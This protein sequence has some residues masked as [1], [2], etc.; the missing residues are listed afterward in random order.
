LSPHYYSSARFKAAFF[1]REPEPI[2]HG[3]VY[4]HGSGRY[5]LFNIIHP[6]PNLRLI[7]DFSRTSLGKGRSKL[8]SK[9]IVVGEKDY[10]FHFV[11][12][13]SARVVSPPLKPEYFEQNAYITLDFGEVPHPIEKEKTGLMRLWGVKFN[14]DDRRLV[15][16]MRDASVITEEQYLALPRPTKINDFPGDLARYPGL[17][18]S[19]LFEDGW[20]AE[21]AF[22]KLGPSRAGQILTFKG[23]IPETKKFR[24][25]GVDVTVSINEKPTEIVNLKSGAFTLT[26][27]IKEATQITS[28]SLHFS[29]AQVYGT[30]DPRAVSASITEISIGDLPDL[31]SFRK[32]VNQK[33][34]KFDLT[35]VDED[36]WIARRS[37]FNAPA[38]D[39]F[40]V[41]KIDLEMP[42]WA[43]VAT[44]ALDVTVNGRV[45]DH[46]DVARMSYVS[47]LLPLTAQQRTAVTLDA[48]NVFALPNDK[49]ERAF[50]I[51]NISFENL[52]PTDLFARGW[53]RSGYLFKLDRADNDGWV[54]RRIAFD[55]PAT[56]QFK[57]A[58][59]EIIRFPAKA[60]LPL[61]V[62]VNGTAQPVVS[63]GLEKT[64]RITVALSADHATGVTLDAPRNF[65]LA[66]PDTRLRSF[67]IV[68]IDFQ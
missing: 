29:D 47:L 42:G 55:F 49:R 62:G 43:P 20:V 67:R 19:G 40:K 51:K 57:T 66:A 6:S 13:G 33:G 32:L 65:A 45:I 50:L 68:N 23:T 38:F 63:L 34:D 24:E 52:S 14:L 1:Q 46:Q 54:D 21:D 48:A 39:A 64:E 8:P 9:A 28:I 16:F 10:P 44:N 5:N 11:G 30:D 22:F 61:S 53:H 37:T 26:R 4:F 7:V 27:L 36:G 56:K 41:L 58:I 3:D 2:T 17:E 18:Y 60:D 12:H 15:G 35:G 25:Q 31:T 59:I